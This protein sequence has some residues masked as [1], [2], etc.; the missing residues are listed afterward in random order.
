MFSLR[1]EIKTSL[2]LIENKPNRHLYQND[3]LTVK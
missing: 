2:L 1:R 3:L